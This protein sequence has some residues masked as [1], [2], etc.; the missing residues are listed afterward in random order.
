ML[1]YADFLDKM[2]RF[3]Q[4]VDTDEVLEASIKNLLTQSLVENLLGPAIKQI[5]SMAKTQAGPRD[6][7]ET[8]LPEPEWARNTIRNWLR[9]LVD[10]FDTLNFADHL[11]HKAEALVKCHGWVMSCKLPDGH[12]HQ[13]AERLQSVQAKFRELL[14]ECHLTNGSDLKPN[15]LV[16]HLFQDLFIAFVSGR[17]DGLKVWMEGPNTLEPT[18]RWSEL[19]KDAESFRSMIENRQGKPKKG[20]A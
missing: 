9:K 3:E 15:D 17:D 16:P 8:A 2:D 10:D 14:S 19:R 1:A 20:K 7:G 11:L 12:D 5:V 6:Q 4:Q 13:D 18:G